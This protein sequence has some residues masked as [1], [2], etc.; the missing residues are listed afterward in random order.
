MSDTTGPPHMQR[1]K[2]QHDGAQREYLVCTPASAPPD[3]PAALV[4][5]FH[6]GGG[7]AELAL[8][9]CRW[10]DVAEREGFIVAAPEALRRAPTRPATFLRNPQFWNA[11]APISYAHS[12]IDDVGFVRAVLDAVQRDRLIDPARIYAAGFSNGASMALRLGIELGDQIAAIGAVAGHLWIP[13]RPPAP[14]VSLIYI[15]GLADP[16]VPFC[17]GNVFTAWGKHVDMPPVAE[18][19]NAWADWLGC[20]GAVRKLCDDGGV[21]L[22]RFG[23]GVGGAEIDFYSVAS[24]GHVWPGGERVLAERLTGPATDRV[25]ATRLIWAFFA[26]HPARR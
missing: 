19:V 2:L 4:L 24:M 12:R 1:R 17:G 22:L 18:T 5:L 6:G 20:R 11:G 15:A 14:P 10:R 3:Q 16:M 7:T 13:P 25:D 26:A 9:A 21:R 8:E 23:P